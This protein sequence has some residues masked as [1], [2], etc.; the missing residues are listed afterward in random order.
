MRGFHAKKEKGLA[1]SPENAEK[2]FAQITRINT[3]RF[4]AKTLRQEGT[5]EGKRSRSDGAD[6]R[7]KISRKDAKTGRRTERKG[8]R[9]KRG[10]RRRLH[11]KKLRQKAQRKK[12][13]IA[14]SSKI[15]E[16]L[17]H[18]CNIL[19]TKYIFQFRSG[20]AIPK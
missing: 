3:E 19:I 11:A 17:R 16:G 7:R 10:K 5:K 2:R 12:K 15:A 4:H 6:E 20:G 8:S 9:R 1:E 18:R 14:E 13:V